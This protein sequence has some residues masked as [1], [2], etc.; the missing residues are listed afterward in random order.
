MC[1]LNQISVSIVLVMFGSGYDGVI[2][3]LGCG[4]YGME[5]SIFYVCYK[6]FVVKEGRVEK[7]CLMMRCRIVVLCVMV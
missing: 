3:E 6:D 2:R 4:E 5:I 7:F 1:I